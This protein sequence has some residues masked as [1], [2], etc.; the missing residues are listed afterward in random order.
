MTSVEGRVE[1]TAAEELV[2]N[3]AG[4]YIRLSGGNIELGCHGNILL[5]SANVQKMGAADYDANKPE[6][7]VGFSEFLLQKMKSPGRFYLY[8][9]QD[10]NR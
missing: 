9:V 4:A 7:P 1:I 3:C 5:K 2:V 6:L 8:P 10:N